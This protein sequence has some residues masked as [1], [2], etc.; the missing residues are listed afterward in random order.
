MDLI[1]IIFPIFTLIAV[2][3]IIRK[4]GLLTRADFDGVENLSFK[5]LLPAM[6]I[7]GIYRSDLSLSTAGPF[8]FAIVL[9]VTLAG[10][11]TMLLR[12]ILGEGRLPPPAY[13]TLFQ[14]TT[15]WNG[16]IALSFAGSVF[17]EPGITLI[18][19]GFA[20]LIP[21]VNVINIIALSVMHGRGLSAAA[22][23]KT[24]AQNPL[25]IASAIGLVLNLAA[26]PLPGFLESTLSFISRATLAIA[27]LVIGAGFELRRLVR[28]DWHVLWAVGLKNLLVPAVFFGVAHWIGLSGIETICGMLIV[29]APAAA[30]GFIVARKMG[31]DAELYA[32]TMTWQLVASVIS[33]P[34]ILSLTV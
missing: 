32:Y 22:I 11:T 15:R 30:N 5:L 16:M 4:R 7:N 28:P 21:Y 9:V 31:G 24:I 34:L 17:D 10:I 12:P 29:S 13:S 25:V 26:I 27:I 14:V 3:Y 8:A 20:V 23:L 18:A 33:I 2:G 1:N 6:I 19:I